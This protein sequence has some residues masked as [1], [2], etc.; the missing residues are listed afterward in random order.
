MFCHSPHANCVCLCLWGTRQ[1]DLSFF[2]MPFFTLF[3]FFFPSSPLSHVFLLLS[4]CHS[5][6]FSF[7]TFVF[8]IRFKLDDEA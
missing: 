2:C 8:R 1:R 5:F 4:F 3:L 7:S 6:F